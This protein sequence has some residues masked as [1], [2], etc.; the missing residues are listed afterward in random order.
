MPCYHP[1]PASIVYDVEAAIP[2]NPEL[3]GARVRK[4]VTLFPRGP[5]TPSH[6]PCGRCLGC[7]TRRAQEW[8]ARV[9]HETRY[10]DRS[11]FATLTYRPDKLP[12]NGE[13]VPRHLQLFLKKLRKAARAG[14]PHVAGQWVRYVACGEY[15]DTTERP[16]YHAIL[17]GVGFDDEQAAGA[18]LK[19]S[20][21]L[22]AIWGHGE[23]MYGDVTAA[24]AAYVAGY[25]MKSMGRVHC[26]RDGVV[27]QAPFLRV[28]T[29]PGIGR[30]YANAYLTDFRSGALVVDGEPRPVP[31]Y[32]K[33][34]MELENPQL[35]EEA[36]EAQ[37]AR[38]FQRQLRDPL[39]STPERL[40][41]AETIQKRKQEL[42]RTHY[43]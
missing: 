12:P 14:A 15:G 10:H 31:R 35:A 39:G 21:T 9:V 26:D 22:T 25:T 32:Y 28:S 2:G 1:I 37:A 38:Q 11:I 34:L 20:P 6:I 19:H 3:G 36:S 27:K 40:V 18:R 5:H 17:F 16:H 29:K 8:A 41:A 4:T 23:V 13:L 43:L 42:T 33:K 7:K 24:S 30:R